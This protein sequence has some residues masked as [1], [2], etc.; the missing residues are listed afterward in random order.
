MIQS[1]LKGFHYN[2][3]AFDIND[4]EGVFWPLTSQWYSKEDCCPYVAYMR[5]TDFSVEKCFCFMLFGGL[6]EYNGGLY[7]DKVTVPDCEFIRI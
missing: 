7:S 6:L 1:I 3:M 5:S 2:F 4:T